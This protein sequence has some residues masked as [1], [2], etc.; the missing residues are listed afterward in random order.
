MSVSNLSETIYNYVVISND[1]I[2]LMY[3]QMESYLANYTSDIY[4]RRSLLRYTGQDCSTTSG[5]S[6]PS[7]LLF[8][9]TVVTSIG[10]GQITPTSW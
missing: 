1:N 7:A 6:F 5:W 4:D 3:T 9:I 8:T 2:S 10:Y